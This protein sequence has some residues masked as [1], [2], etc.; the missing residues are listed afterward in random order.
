M[1]DVIF[2][3][4]SNRPESREFPEVQMLQNGVRVSE[5]T[6]FSA[7]GPVAAAPPSVEPRG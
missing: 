6:L 4:V 2:E 3:I 7:S 1:K 5:Q